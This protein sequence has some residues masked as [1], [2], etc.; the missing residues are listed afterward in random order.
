[1]KL[2]LTFRIAYVCAS[3]KADTAYIR[4]NTHLYGIN[5]HVPDFN[6][7]WPTLTKEMKRKKLHEQECSAYKGIKHK[8]DGRQFFFF[9]FFIRISFAS[10][11][12]TPNEPQTQKGF[13]F[14]M[15]LLTFSHCVFH[16]LPIIFFFFSVVC[17]FTFFSSNRNFTVNSKNWLPKQPKKKLKK[18]K[19]WIFPIFGWFTVSLL[20]LFWNRNGGK[21]IVRLP[22]INISLYIVVKTASS[23]AQNASVPIWLHHHQL[24]TKFFL[25]FM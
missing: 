19:Y 16:V 1:M 13:T 22:T 25:L 5:T 23:H 8:T 18:T 21:N 17:L 4:R 9:Y 7:N 12:H 3:A 2:H 20:F 15:R 14:S 6:S 10:V 24:R 11:C